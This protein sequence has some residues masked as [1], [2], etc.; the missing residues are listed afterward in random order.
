MIVEIKSFL[1]LLVLVGLAVVAGLAFKPLV[2]VT[3][4]TFT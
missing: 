3:S 2:G 4:K 1:L